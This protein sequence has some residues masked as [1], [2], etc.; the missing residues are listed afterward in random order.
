MN[1]AKENFLSSK[2]LQI[3]ADFK[4]QFL[5]LLMDIGFVPGDLHLHRRKNGPDKILEI[6]GRDVSVI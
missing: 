5:E 3:L 2:T 4:F 1:F 6:T